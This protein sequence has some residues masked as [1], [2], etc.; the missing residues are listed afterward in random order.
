M[1]FAWTAPDSCPAAPAVE[2]RIEE[3][4]GGPLD[5]G[6]HRIAVVVTREGEVFVARVALDD[7]DARTLDAPSCDDLLD[8]VAIGIIGACDGPTSIYVTSKFAPHLL[9]AVSV[10]A[11]SY[12][13]LV[14]LIQP[15]IM[16][17]LT[18]EREKRIVMPYPTKSVSMQTRRIASAVACRSIA[19]R[20]LRGSWP[21]AA[22]RG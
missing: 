2:A 13:A 17:L 11:Y 10:A 21:H 8:A 12:M 6:D 14:P 7:A 15:P 18:T 1:S 20:R 16:R 3:R 22:A 4:L 5:V 9:G 19:I